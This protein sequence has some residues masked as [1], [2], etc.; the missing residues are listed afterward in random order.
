M[1][2]YVNKIVD[3]SGVE[4]DIQ[5][6]RVPQAS[7]ADAG[8]ALK[9]SDEGQ[10]EFGDVSAGEVVYDL[11]ANQNATVGDL[12]DLAGG[13]T[14][15]ECVIRSFYWGGVHDDKGI[16]NMTSYG[17]GMYARFAKVEMPSYYEY[18]LDGAASTVRAVPLVNFIRGNPPTTLK[19]YQ[20]PSN[21]AN[22]ASQ[23][24]VLTVNDQG[25]MAWMAPSSGGTQLY[26]H[27]ITCDIEVDGQTYQNAIVRFVSTFAD[28]VTSLSAQ[29][30]LPVVGSVYYAYGANTA[31]SFDTIWFSAGGNLITNYFVY[32]DQNVDGN[33][34]LV[35]KTFQFGSTIADNVTAL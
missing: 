32:A 19:P 28:Q 35:K 25:N 31:H 18:V 3:K 24:D 13:V 8:K 15:Q 16:L 27:N 6:K 2:D 30:E 22:V 11:S 1:S 34:I 4:F 12:Y 26:R 21:P 20:M 33:D 17:S 29:T 5:D 14:N 7:V 10:L 9:V 23:G